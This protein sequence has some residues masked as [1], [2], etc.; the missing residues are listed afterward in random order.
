M[1]AGETV[2]G[3]TTLAGAAADAN[4]GGTSAASAPAA[5]GGGDA[6]VPMG[7][8]GAAGAARADSY[9]G[10]EPIDPSQ[11]FQVRSVG[12]DIAANTEVEYCEVAQLPGSPDDVYW[13]NDTELAN[14]KGSHHLI[15]S[16]ADP[17]GAAEQRIKLLKV[18]DRVPCN[19]AQIAFGEAG[20]TSV[21]GIQQPYDRFVLPDGVGRKYLGAQYLIFDYHFLNSTSQT[22]H[23]RSAINFHTTDGSKIKHIA[24]SFS[25]FNYTIAT[26]PHSSQAFTGECRLKH[27][28]MVGGLAR[29]THK[30]GT[31]FDVWFAGGARDG[32]HI[33]T[34][35]HWEE[36]TQYEFPMPTLVK[37]GEG[38][39]FQCGYTN[40]GESSLR[41]GTS[42]RDEMC[43]LFGSMWA[44]KDGEQVDTSECDISW[45]DD[46]GI[47][48]PADEAGGVPKAPLLTAATCELFTGAATDCEKCTCESCGAPS[49]GC[50]LDADCSA[51]LK[52]YADCAAGAASGTSHEEM[53]MNCVSKCSDSMQEHSSA[54]GLLQQ[55]RLCRN[56][57]CSM[58]P[59]L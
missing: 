43:I 52:C 41:F 53:A 32:E 51:V 37:T 11:G 18:G 33:W 29:H 23:A 48:H 15:I 9:L 7:T 6:S 40:P 42:T 8:G 36:D 54:V 2:V 35:E 14:G 26:P 1:S 28:V 55:A 30:F 38:F 12:A 39:R 19:A 31:N 57:M 27:D 50:S 47:G 20:L 46:Q 59:L 16:V 44:A 10:L 3:S 49:V 56:T 45:I 21:G 13:V 58:C 34:S 4:S 17:G 24:S 22:I 5:E 25:F